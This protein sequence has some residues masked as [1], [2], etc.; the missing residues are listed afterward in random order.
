M[1]RRILIIDDTETMRLFEKMMLSGLGYEIETAVDGLDGL[2]KLASFRADLVLLD[3]MMPRL[4]GIETCRRLKGDPATSHIK[5]VMVTSREEYERVKEAFAAGCD[6]YVT[7]PVDRAE[8][9]GK[10][11]E[12]LRFVEV[13]ETLSGG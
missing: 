3:V 10:V 11:E 4:D 6:D 7:K 2:E 9:V 12:L 5:V 8:L 1:A 13:R